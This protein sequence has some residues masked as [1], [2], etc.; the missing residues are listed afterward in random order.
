MTER[1][2][3]LIGETM[4]RY[5]S[6]DPNKFILIRQAAIDLFYQKGINNSSMQEIAKE[7]GI[8]KGTIYLY[9]NNRDELVT[10][11]FHYCYELHMEASMVDVEIQKS[12]SEKLKKRIK[13]LL[14]WNS[15][16]PKESSM[17]SSYY[18]PVN[19]AGTEE[20]VFAKSYDINKGYL[21][22]GI[23]DGEFKKLPLDFLC[24][25]LFSY[26]EGISTYIKSNRD[27]VEDQ[28]Q[29]EKMLETMVSGFKQF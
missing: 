20:S 4:A 8:A 25:L 28:E 2:S 5:T 13:N 26:V 3:I 23:A 24:A 29:L 10:S 17:I 1:S 22:D 19:L 7:A 9:Y 6:L 11:V 12:N 18:R 21:R 27:L 14:L 16:H 15:S